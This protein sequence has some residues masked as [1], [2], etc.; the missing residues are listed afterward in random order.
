MICLSTECTCFSVIL[1]R[2][3]F[4]CHTCIVTVRVILSYSI[5]TVKLMRDKIGGVRRCCNV[6]DGD[7]DFVERYLFWCDGVDAVCEGTN[8]LVEVN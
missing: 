2:H 4:S 6:V 8:W 7:A 1:I 5:D 3:E